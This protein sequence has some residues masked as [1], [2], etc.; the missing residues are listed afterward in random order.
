MIARPFAGPGRA[1]YTL[2]EVLV[3]T[4]IALLLLAGLYVALDVTLVRMDASRDQV[5]VSDL[6]RAVVN[7]VAADLANTLGP[8]PPKSGG[9]SAGASTTGSAAAG[10]APMG[11]GANAGAAPTGT[12]AATGTPMPMPTTGAGTPAPT[13]PADS[14]APMPGA[15]GEPPQTLLP[16]G[17]GVV[18]TA[19]Q[20]TLFG[21]RVPTS[22]VDA[23]AAAS[24]VALPG[25]Q[26]RVIYY[27]A[28]DGS[29][30]C[31]Q[32]RPWVTADGVG[33]STEPDRSTEAEDL[34]APEVKAFDLEYYDGGSWMGAWD[35]AV[36][37]LDGVSL[38][39][40]PRAVRVT[41]TLEIPGRNGA[42]TTQRKVQ[43]TIAVRA[44]VGN[45]QGPEP[46]PAADPDAA[47]TTPG[48]AE[49]N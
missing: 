16:F 27:M 37:D 47:T 48:T 38:T 25:D 40:P 33:T 20:L 8:L 9:E 45:Y 10:A 41:L 29:G 39:G 32:E 19:N 34:I 18:G 35:G 7:R 6:S 13:T 31:R 24:Q 1:G 44:A 28:S 26:R 36:T 17:M 5:M 12:G 49:G 43:H 42:A 22:L 21:S 46:P 14:G 3:A 23:E 4:A 30:L 11:T 15:G 2:L